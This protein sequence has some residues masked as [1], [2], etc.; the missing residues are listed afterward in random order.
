MKKAQEAAARPPRGSNPLAGIFAPENLVRIAGHP[1]YSKYLADEDFMAKVQQLQTDPTAFQTVLLQDKRVMDVFGFL[2]GIDMRGGPMGAEE[3]EE[4]E[5][6]RQ[7]AAAAAASAPAPAPAPEPEPAEE[8]LTEEERELRK[9]KREAVEHKEV[10]W[11]LG[12]GGVEGGR[13]RSVVWCLPP[14]QPPE[15]TPHSYVNKYLHRRRNAPTYTPQRGNQHYAK[16][17]FAEALAAYDAAIALD[18]GNMAFRTNKV[19]LDY[20]C[21]CHHPPPPRV[22]VAVSD[23]PFNPT[24]HH[25][26]PNPEPKPTGGRL[27]GAG[28]V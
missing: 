15:S 27:H 25:N 19:R 14:T 28:P 5:Q 7:R 10:G 13:G 3:E 12:C 26:P 17:E 4:E 8:E 16:K 20:R 6:E 21:V 23:S 24:T 1:V 22:A 9:R 2:T 18:E 11:G